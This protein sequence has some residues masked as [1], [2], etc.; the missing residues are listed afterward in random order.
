ARPQRSRSSGSGSRS[1]TSRSRGGPAGGRSRRGAQ[2]SRPRNAA[3]V[4]S[5]DLVERQLLG[6]MLRNRAGA[7]DVAAELREGDCRADAHRCVLRAILNLVERQAP[8]E[9]TSV[10][11]EILRQGW[12]E[13]LG[14]TQ[15]MY[16]FLAELVEAEPTGVNLPYYARQVRDRAIQ[17]QLHD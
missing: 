8:V 2:M 4:E 7:A 5:A 1:A 16:A 9:P 14:G 6:G 12:V 15:L 17:R 13:R 3:A 10:A 11:G